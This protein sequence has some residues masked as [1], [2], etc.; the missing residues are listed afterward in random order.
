M[1]ACVLGLLV[2]NQ[3]QF[4]SYHPQRGQKPS[5]RR[6]E[7][8]SWAPPSS[9]H[10]VPDPPWASTSPRVTSTEPTSPCSATA[11]RGSAGASSATDRRSPG[12]APGLEAN[13]C[14]SES[15]VCRDK[16]TISPAM[17]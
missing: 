1:G 12:L 14:V 10:A 13:R 7:T 5:V 2:Q 6:T 4:C 11:A 8:A 9:A 3:V 16:G 17:C 15:H